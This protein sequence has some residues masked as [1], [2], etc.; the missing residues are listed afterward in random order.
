MKPN[1]ILSKWL[2]RRLISVITKRVAAIVTAQ[3]KKTREEIKQL[4]EDLL[5]ELKK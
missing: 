5:E 2:E 4:R 1:E 3:A